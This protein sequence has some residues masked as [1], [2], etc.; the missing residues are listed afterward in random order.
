MR[1]KLDR[2][3]RVAAIASRQKGLVTTA[4]LRHAG[5]DE[6]SIARRVAAGRLHPIHR[7]VY[8]VGHVGIGREAGWMAAGLALGRGAVLSH[9]SAAALWGMLKPSG[10]QIHVTVPTDGGRSCRKGI[11][12][13]RST[14]LLPSQTTARGGIPV[15]K[16]ARTLRD[17]RRVAARSA[18]ARALRQAEYL[19]LPLDGLFDPDGTRSDHEAELL[20]LVRRHRLPPPEVNARLGPYVVDF[21]WRERGLVVE[22]D[23]YGT[24]GG[25]A[26]CPGDRD[27]ARAAFP[28]PAVVSVGASLGPGR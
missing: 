7:G 19:R 18:W 5:H 4:Q 16:P 26:M 15:T 3:A 9:T 24:H 22:M 28:H 6:S 2:D 23:A 10:G 13:H 12:I 17:L 27:L 14:T 25:R 8:A 1:Q 20:R 21:L 11:A